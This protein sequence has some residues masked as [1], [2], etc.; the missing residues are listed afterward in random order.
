MQQIVKLRGLLDLLFVFFFLR[1]QDILNSM[2]QVKGST[3]EVSRKA[4]ELEFQITT[5]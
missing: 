4:N 3:D 1:I 2:R 5:L